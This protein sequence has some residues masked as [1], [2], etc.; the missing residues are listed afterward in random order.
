[1]PPLPITLPVFWKFGKQF[2]F[3]GKRRGLQQRKSFATFPPALYAAKNRYVL[4]SLTSIDWG[5]KAV[6]SMTE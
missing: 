5:G 6:R 3:L 1:M 4:S 2:C